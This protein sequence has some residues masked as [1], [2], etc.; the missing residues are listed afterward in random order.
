IEHGRAGVTSGAAQCCGGWLTG[1]A[2]AGSA[3]S[4]VIASTN[5][6]FAAVPAGE[7][8]ANCAGRWQFDGPARAALPR[9]GHRRS[10]GDLLETLR[11]SARL[12]MT[13]GAF[14]GME[15]GNFA[16]Q[17]GAPG[18]RD[19]ATDTNAMPFKTLSATMIL[20]DGFVSSHDFHV[21]SA[22]FTADLDFK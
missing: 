17:V 8:L 15:L 9:S 13:D 11:G 1:R 16:A 18:I 4:G 7:A 19:N 22:D 20:S 14:R 10:W 12:D 6:R 2:S 21:E 5:R 3:G